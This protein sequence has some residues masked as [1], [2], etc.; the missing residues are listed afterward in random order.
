[1][2]GFERKIRRNNE[3][4]ENEEIKKMYGKKPKEKCPLC[5]QKSLFYTNNKGEV[6]CMRCNEIVH[7]K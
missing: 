2:S 4:T 1:M 5:K 7:I 6:Y 3:K